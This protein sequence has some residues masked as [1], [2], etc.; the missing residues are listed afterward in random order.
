MAVR[1]RN[2][3]SMDRFMKT[4]LI[5]VVFLLAAILIVVAMQE[6]PIV[7]I[8]DEIVVKSTIEVLAAQ[9]KYVAFGLGEMELE[10]GFNGPILF[11][12]NNS[13]LLD[14]YYVDYV[15][16]SW[17]P[18]FIPG[19]ERNPITTVKLVHHSTQPTG[20]QT[21][22]APVIFD[23]NFPRADSL[24]GA[25]VLAW[26]GGNNVG[27][28]GSLGGTSSSGFTFNEGFNKIELTQTLVVKA[29]G[30][31]RFDVKTE[32]AGHLRFGVFGL[33]TKK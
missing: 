23:Q 27:M 16:V 29:G 21:T 25:F 22:P 18:R 8:P 9:G 11:F 20:F 24:N 14:D 26:R 33:F 17:H 5:V 4:M 28:T 30:S 2:E 1:I 15:M 32:E 6:P 12:K 3:V 31:I 13:S 10:S 7:N 19:T